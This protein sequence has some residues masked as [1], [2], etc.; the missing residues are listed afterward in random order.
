LFF[1]TDGKISQSITAEKWA[2]GQNAVKSLLDVIDENEGIVDYKSLERVRGFLCHLSMTF[3]V[4]TPFLKGFHLVLAKHLPRRDEDGWNFS[5]KHYMSYLHQ[6]LADDEV[7]KTEAE[8]MLKAAEEQGPEAP[9]ALPATERLKQDLYALGEILKPASPPDVLIR[10]NAVLQVLY[11]FGDASGK[12]FGSTLLSNRGMKFRIGL[13][14]TDAEDES[15]NWKEFEN[16]VEALE[17]EGQ[18]SSLDGCLVY[19]FTDNSTVEAALYKGNSS[20]PKLFDL[21]VRFKKLETHHKARF[22]V[23]HVSGKRMI[24]Q[25]SDAVSRGQ[26]GQGVTAGTDMLSFIPLDKSALER[27]PILLKDWIQA[28]SGSGTE[29][30]QPEGWFERSH[31]LIGGELDEYGHWAPKHKSGTFVW[32]PPPAAAAVAIEELRKARIKW[33]GSLH[34]VI[35]PHL[36]TPEWLRQLYKVSDLV[37]AVPPSPSFWPEAML[38]PLVIELI[39]PFAR[40]APWQLRGTPKMLAMGRQMRRVFDE[41]EVVGGNILRKFL[42]ECRWLPTPPHHKRDGDTWV[43]IYPIWA[44]PRCAIYYFFHS[45]MVAH[46]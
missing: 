1:T 17:E 29:F 39:F 30:L 40:S 27:S 10:S 28:W 24:A 15:S 23:S 7:S 31:D 14:E 32:V 25:G 44:P 5:E 34:V 4:I 18:S 6:K 45:G 37:F 46:T 43:P 42:L 35:I 12:G 21:V 11:G 38:E 20:S 3:E 36:L 8:L 16:V 26:L 41:E 33:Q 2:K 19:F 9:K 22:L 13:W